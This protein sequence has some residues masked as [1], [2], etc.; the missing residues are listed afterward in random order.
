ML[1]TIVATYPLLSSMC[2]AMP[3]IYTCVVTWYKHVLLFTWV[4]TYQKNPF[5]SETCHLLNAHIPINFKDYIVILTTCNDTCRRGKYR[6]VTTFCFKSRTFSSPKFW[7]EIILSFFLQWQSPHS[8]AAI[9]AP[10]VQDVRG[11]E[12]GRPH[13]LPVWQGPRRQLGSHLLHLQEGLR[14]LPE[15]GEGSAK[16]HIFK[17]LYRRLSLFIYIYLLQSSSA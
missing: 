17:Y 13:P 9:L 12:G 6:H 2:H 10:G 7:I 4:V 1:Q 16:C 15:D 3:L 5:M 8:A 14:R 11:W